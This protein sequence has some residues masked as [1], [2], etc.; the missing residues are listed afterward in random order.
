MAVDAASVR[1]GA[2]A[3]ALALGATHAVAGVVV[4]SFALRLAL[5][6]AH[7]TPYIFPDEYIY[8]ALARELV[9]SGRP[10]V[11][12]GTSFFPA[13]LEPLLVAPF[14]L[15]GDPGLAYRLTQ[16]AH[17]LAMSLAAVPA[18]LLARRVGL[19]NAAA[20]SVAAIAVAVPDLV[21][22][23]FMLAEPVGYPLA[24]AAV[25]AGVRALERPTPR[26]QLLFL[27]F[28][29]L[30]T[31]ARLQYGVIVFAFLLAA[32]IVERRALRI[33]LT[34]VAAAVTVG[35]VVDP[36]RAL[37]PY[38]GLA[39]WEPSAGDLMHWT[40]SQALL[41]GWAAGVA[42]V[43]A[44]L[45]GVVVALRRPRSTAERAFAVL[46]S[47]FAVLLVFEAVMIADFESGRFEERYLFALVPLLAIAAARWVAH[48]RPWRL[49]VVAAA[50][51]VVVVSL[52]VP[53]SGYVVGLGKVDSPLLWS[54]WHLSQATSI[55][56]A[57]LV[58]V[59]AITVAAA[60]GA[61][62][63]F[64]RR[65]F[66]LLVATT[67]LSFGAVSAGAYAHALD[68]AEIVRAQD[69]PAD[70]RWVDRFGLEDVALL[71]T[72]NGSRRSAMEQ[73]FWNRSVR[74]VLLLGGA[75]PFDSFG[76]WRVQVNRD[77]SLSLRGRP[78]VRPL[79][80]Q[81]HAVTVDFRGAE[82]VAR[83]GT[84]ELWRPQGRPRLSLLVAGRFQ[85]GWLARGGSIFVWPDDRGNT[86][87]TLRLVVSM[88]V[89][90][91]AT[92][93]RI[94]GRG[95]DQRLVVRPGERREVAVRL[96]AC[97]PVA[98]SFGTTKW[99][100]LADTRQ[101]SVRAERPTFSPIQAPARRC[102]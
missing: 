63:G 36:A 98:L 37:G 22:V 50:A 10:I 95:V 68:N 21:Y 64:V 27:T 87:G 1:A 82:R 54:V 38:R 5:A 11:R 7:A 28:A 48:A 40:G 6:L 26:A 29:G 66:A 51:A 13:F 42:L 71:Q 25:Y 8:P 59:T 60:L 96:D 33:P 46:T 81:T 35:L 70:A 9:E 12:E 83:G 69:L 91:Q 90:T 79:L 88:P 100:L 84:F 85:D 31:A 34:A 72:P 97:G 30:A 102:R 19:A 58:V 49:A 18:F 80:V 101:V 78:L 53:I 92:P 23:S 43:P 94:A 41:L 56:A 61:V 16:A 20:V 52:Q 39:Q 77:G 44:A 57:S 55:G 14:Q 47:A 32:L 89:D 45:A 99:G 76:A 2:S 65:P 4:A 73:M 67:L 74:D 17:A 15:V 24:L 3:R 62:A 86:S 75:E 93:L